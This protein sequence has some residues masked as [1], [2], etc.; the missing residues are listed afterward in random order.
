MSKLTLKTLLNV[1]TSNLPLQKNFG[2]KFKHQIKHNIHKYEGL[3]A[4]LILFFIGEAF[5]IQGHEVTETD[6]EI[7]FNLPV[8]GVTLGEWYTI[9]IDVYENNEKAN[10][11]SYGKQIVLAEEEHPQPDD[12]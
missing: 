12:Y 6:R 5:I 2:V 10:K 9:W 11:L 7:T 4:I 3:Y 8:E 1:S